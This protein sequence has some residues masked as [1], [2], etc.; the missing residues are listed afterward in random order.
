V[1]TLG[2]AGEPSAP[3]ARTKEEPCEVKLDLLEQV[4]DHRNIMK[5][6]KRVEEN[7]GAPGIDGMKTKELRAYLVANWKDLRSELLAGTYEPQPVRRVEVSV[8]QR[9]SVPA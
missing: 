2:P 5:A 7:K 1:N 3:P 6:L 9:K 8:C 4:L